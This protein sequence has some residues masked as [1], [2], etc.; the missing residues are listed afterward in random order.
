MASC[1]LKTVNSP[2]TPAIGK[3]D[4][5]PTNTSVFVASKSK[6][7]FVPLQVFITTGNGRSLFRFPKPS[8]DLFK[9]EKPTL[10]D[11][12]QQA[13]VKCE[14]GRITTKTKSS[15]VSR[16]DVMESLTTGILG[17]ALLPK[18]AEAR[19]SRL[20]MKKMILEKLE[21]LKQ[22]AG[23]SKPK[24]ENE[25]KLPKIEN[26]VKPPTKPSPEDKQ[27]PTKPSPE[28]KKPP[29]LPLP[30]PELTAKPL[31]EATLSDIPPPKGAL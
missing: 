13:K 22:K 12:F 4:L 3:R 11:R 9:P 26:D 25:M 29:T 16:R 5:L 27:S 1:N 24:T 18:P 7:A 8:I 31:V 15:S 19:I 28:E 6:T 14:K 21:E 10:V 2:L 17:L 23:L 20:E 30:P